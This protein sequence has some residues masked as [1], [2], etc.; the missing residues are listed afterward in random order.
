MTARRSRTRQEEPTPPSSGGRERSRPILD[1]DGARRLDRILAERLS[2][3]SLLLMER[4]AL[5]LATATLK[6]I[7]RGQLPRPT[8]L[9]PC[10]VICGPGN[11]GGDGYAAARHLAAAGVPVRIA[12]IAPPRPDS[13]AAVMHAIARRYA[14][15]GL[16][17]EFVGGDAD[18]SGLDDW[19][20]KPALLVDALFGTGL[21]RELADEPLAW[22]A[23]ANRLA[24][25][26]VAADL[27]SGL[28]ADTG[29]LRGGAI[30][31]AVTVTFAAI[32]PAM[33]VLSAQSFLGEVVVATIGEPEAILRECSLRPP[34]R[35]TGEPRERSRA[36][37]GNRRDRG[38][39]L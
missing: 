12:A 11:N 21:D 38:L 34:G 30:R 26:I 17:L 29:R 33:R 5:G 22:V 2:M 35:S 18:R 3:P 27:P 25:P 32:K 9:K 10:L 16:G 36:P 20:R 15:E 31:A 19:P 4:A 7:E 28:D 1:R 23:A 6:R 24:V 39:D 13:D 8:R 37:G 14:T